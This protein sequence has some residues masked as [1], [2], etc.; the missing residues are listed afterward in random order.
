MRSSVSITPSLVR[1]WKIETQGDGQSET[2]IELPIHAFE[3]ELDEYTDF[4]EEKLKKGMKGWEMVVRLLKKTTEDGSSVFAF[5]YHS[6]N[7]MI[8]GLYTQN[9]VV[10]EQTEVGTYSTTLYTSGDDDSVKKSGEFLRRVCL[11]V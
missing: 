7:P 3:E 8:A 10:I 5:I 1:R 6:T 4:I 11:G 9:R 2:K